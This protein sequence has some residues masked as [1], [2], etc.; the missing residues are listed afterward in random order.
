MLWVAPVMQTI[1]IGQAFA[2]TAL[3]N[4]GGGTLSEGR[5]IPDSPIDPDR[6]RLPPNKYRYDIAVCN[7]GSLLITDISVTLKVASLACRL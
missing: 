2:Q 7:C 4:P 5:L 3:V 6:T 1:S